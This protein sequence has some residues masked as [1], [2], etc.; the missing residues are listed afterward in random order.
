MRFSIR[1][2]GAR[3]NISVRRVRTPSCG[4]FRTPISSDDVR[5]TW[6]RNWL[7][8]NDGE[9]KKGRQDR[10]SGFRN[11]WLQLALSVICVFVSE[12]LLK[13]GVTDIAE[14]DS[15]WPGTGVNGQFS[16]LFWGAF[17][18]IFP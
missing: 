17:L 3:L 7:R 14:P 2:S 15:A 8:R 1:Y 11:P 13:R 16:P 9:L 4:G 5:P 18:L 12:L 6:E 10:P